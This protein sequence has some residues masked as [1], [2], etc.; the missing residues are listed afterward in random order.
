MQ[1]L[2]DFHLQSTYPVASSTSV[3]SAS[4]S[5]FAGDKLQVIT[6]YNQQGFLTTMTVPF[7]TGRPS[8]DYRGFLISAQAA[9]TAISP[10]PGLATSAAVNSEAGSLTAYAT[11]AAGTPSLF[12]TGTVSRFSGTVHPATALQAQATGGAWKI[13][14]LNGMGAACALVGAVLL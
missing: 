14:K 2:T 7:A 3:P 13:S 6:T 12:A 10:E 9:C 8:Y 4:C 11:P 1:S 5:D